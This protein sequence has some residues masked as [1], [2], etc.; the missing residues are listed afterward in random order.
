MR[1][2]GI[3]GL[4][5]IAGSLA[6]YTLGVPFLDL[7]ELKTVDLRF[8]SRGEISPKNKILLA[9]IDEKSIE[10]EGK[11][12]WPRSRFATLVDVLSGAGAKVIA[13][14]IGF[15]EPDKRGM[16]VIRTISSIEKEILEMG[17]HTEKMAAY[18]DFLKKHA[19]DDA[20]LAEAIGNSSAKVVLGYF[21]HLG[22]SLPVGYNKDRLE[23]EIRNVSSS[24]YKIV[25][26]D[27]EA[28]PEAA[29]SFLAKAAA[30]E[31]NID[32]ISRQTDISGFFNMLP[33]VDGVVRWIPIAIHLDSFIYAPL[34]LAAAAAYLNEPFSIRLAQFGVESLHIGDLSVPV[35]EDGR[36]LVNYRG[37]VKT[38]PHISITDI[39]NHRFEKDTFRD[40]IV[41]VGATAI[42]IY[43]HRVT[44]FGQVFPGLEVHANILDSIL[45]GDVL[46]RPKWHALFDI[47]AI[48]FACTILIFALPRT[49]A[50]SGALVFLLFFGGYIFI[51]RFL[52]VKWGMIINM[53]YPLITAL[54]M[55][56]S[57]T[58]Y[59]YFSEFRQKAFIRNA[60]STYLAPSVVKTLIDSP[61]KLVLG[62]E[63]RV[64]TAFFSDL[65]GFTGISEKLSPKELVEILNIFLTEMTE[66]ILKY[67]GTVDKFEGDAII[68]FFGAPNDLEH[69][70]EAAAS[71][72]IEMQRRLS[73]MREEW[74][75]RNRPLLNMRIG[76]NT[77]P[78]VVGN[79]GSKNRMDY[80]MMGDTVNLAARLEGANKVYGTNTM[81]TQATAA[82]LDPGRFFIR[83]LDTI[84]VL[85]RKEPVR[86][87]ELIGFIQ[88]AKPEH[89]EMAA[90]YREALVHYRQR[91]WKEALHLFE[92]ILSGFPHDG[93]SLTMKKRCISFQKSPPGPGW[94]GVFHMSTK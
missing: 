17:L 45:A 93:P 79:M 4:I 60:F 2:P 66:F 70:E 78:A 31:S 52:F 75:A 68:A 42:G 62:G 35:E 6:F 13:F 88:D 20:I 41:L 83:E 65:Q 15:L 90:R 16:E 47:A 22:D 69:Q 7:M 94:E 19:D 58:M 86:I 82:K 32:I 5:V 34:T 23:E 50:V 37:D 49:G 87:Y 40:A 8:L 11:W 9:V 46:H 64:I 28:D 92:E 53:T 80:T 30:P 61:E 85:G 14:D 51:S 54:V 38:F 81:I 55:Y 29:R 44:P 27:Q 57:L 72:S 18:L 76:L 12:M 91:K 77:G 84:H 24:L 26:Y 3:I 33:D 1:T 73:H 89:I 59:K 63:E 10:A 56:I 36:I 48:L 43:D 25:R 39:L 74:K 21:F 71:A 67:E